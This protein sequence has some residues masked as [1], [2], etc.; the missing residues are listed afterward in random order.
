MNLYFIK[1][2]LHFIEIHL[3]IEWLVQNVILAFYH[4]FLTVPYLNPFLLSIHFVYGTENYISV[5]KQI[6]S[7]EFKLIHTEFIKSF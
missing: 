4:I 3:K 6:M 5:T 1:M 2:H 7:L